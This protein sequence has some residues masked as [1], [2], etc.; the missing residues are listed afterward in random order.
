MLLPIASQKAGPIWLIFFV[1]THGGQGVLK[2]K[3]IL[4]FVLI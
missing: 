2:A 1:D 3:K 4:N